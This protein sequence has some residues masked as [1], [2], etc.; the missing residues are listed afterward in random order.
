M[1]VSATGVRCLEALDSKR[2]LKQKQDLWEGERKKMK[3]KRISTTASSKELIF[4]GA[5][6]CHRGCTRLG[7]AD[8]MICGSQKRSRCGTGVSE[9]GQPEMKSEDRAS[10][11]RRERRQEQEPESSNV[12]DLLRPEG[13]PESTSGQRNLEHVR[14][15]LRPEGLPASTSRQREQEQD[16]EVESTNVRD[17][18]RPDGLPESTYG[19]PKEESSNVRALLRP[20][21]LPASTFGQRGH[22]QEQTVNSTNNPMKLLEDR[23]GRTTF[24]WPQAANA[25]HLP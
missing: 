17:Q 11:E 6:K 13:L 24:A 25:M 14:A 20:D 23:S 5:G 21:G 2:R 12:R 8:K 1:E 4:R 18:L 19:P 7:G 15:L 3:A 9:Q 22:E 10:A 16:P